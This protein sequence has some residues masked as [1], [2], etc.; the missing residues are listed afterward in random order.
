MDEVMAD[1]I[2]KFAEIYWKNHQ[3]KIDISQ[4]RGK[5]L[6][7][8]LPTELKPTIKKYINEPGFFRNLK[9][10]PDCQEVVL[11]LQKKYDVYIVSAAM[12]FR[13]SLVDK[14]DWLK[15]HFPEISW[16]NIVFCGIKIIDVH[17]IIDDRTKNFKDFHGRKI[18]FSSPHNL[19]IEE[20]E[21]V[22]NWKEVAEKFL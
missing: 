3:F 7:E 13:N 20:H 19:L 15:D 11:E 14:Y 8:M 6:G 2:D 22:D 16:T 1:T 9:I 17:A 18:L 5:E 10:M 21:R 4:M 12:E